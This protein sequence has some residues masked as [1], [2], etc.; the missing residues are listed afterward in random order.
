[1]HT[2]MV[3]Q[4]QKLANP[5]VERLIDRRT[6]QTTVTRWLSKLQPGVLLF[7]PNSRSVL[8]HTW[9]WKSVQLLGG[10]NKVFKKT[11][12]FLP[13]SLLY[14]YTSIYSAWVHSQNHLPTLFTSMLTWG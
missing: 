13:L 4:A 1:M 12:S 2:I 6:C 8:F 14:S 7:S 9:G 10:I 5:K 11:H 3:G